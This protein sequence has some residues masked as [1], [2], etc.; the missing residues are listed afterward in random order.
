MQEV[1][2]GIQRKTKQQQQQELIEWRRSQVIELISKGKNLTQTAEILRVDVSTV[3]RDYQY[4]RENANKVLKKYFAETVPLEVTKCLS[5]LNAISN[6]A[7][8]MAEQDGINEKT[9]LSALSLAQDAALHIVN[10]ITNNKPL[11]DE[12]FTFAV[13]EQQRC[14]LAGDHERKSLRSQEEEGQE[15]CYNELSDKDTESR[16]EDAIAAED[17]LF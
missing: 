3:C 9:K 8:K 1:S 16:E 5:R 4:I 15:G 2:S 17:T 10:V 12:A 7:W 14:T 13:D 11:I 6:E